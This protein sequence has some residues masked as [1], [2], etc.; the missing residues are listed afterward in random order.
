M[1]QPESLHPQRL[2]NVASKR[3]FAIFIVVVICTSESFADAYDS[4]FV[5]GFDRFHRESTE[6]A[7]SGGR[8]LVSELSCTACHASPDPELQPKRGPNLAGAGQRYQPGW[9]Q[10]YLANPQAIKPGTVMPDVMHDFTDDQRRQAADAIAA[11]LSV[12]NPDYPILESTASNPVAEEFWRKGDQE[13]GAELYHQVGCVACHEPNE[14]FPAAPYQG[15]DVQKLLSQLDPDEIEEL[16][17][18]D[19][20]RRVRSVPHG[21][22]AG[23]Y[24][25]KSLAFFLYAPERTR[26]SGRMPSFNL[27]PDEAAD[28]ASYLIGDPAKEDQDPRQ[29]Y[30]ASLVESGKRFFA[31]LRCAQCHSMDELKPSFA[32]KPLVD[33]NFAAAQT[34]AGKRSVG[35]PFYGLDPVQVRSI[36]SALESMGEQ[37]IGDAPADV[38]MLKLNCYACHQRGRRG[39][40]GPNRRRYFETVGNVDIGDEGRLPPPLDGVGRKLRSS[41]LDDALKATINVRPHMFVRM[42]KFSA[43]SMA[44]LAGEFIAADAAEESGDLFP[45]DTAK[46]A[47]SGRMLFDTGCVQCH[48]VRGEHLPG[49]LGIDLTGATKRLRAQWFHDFLLDPGSLKSRTRMPTF[50]PDGRSV[51]SEI[52][53]GDTEGQIASLW[54]YINDIENQPLPQKIEDGKAHDFELIPNEQPI[55]LRTFMKDVGTHAIAVGF[56]QKV[57]YAFDAEMARLA[58]AWRGRFIDAH[59]TWFDRFTPPAVP[60]GDDVVGFPTGVALATLASDDSPWPTNG[61]ATIRFGGFR[62]D[63]RGVPTFIYR[64][65]GFDIEDRLTPDEQGGLTRSIQVKPA[66]HEAAKPA[67][68]WFLGN[69]GKNL[70]RE[71]ARSY[72]NEDKLTVTMLQPLK[73]LGVVREINGVYEWIIPIKPEGAISIEVNYR[74]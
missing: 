33:L 47:S 67:E 20:I 63:Q 16:G 13:R 65:D 21:D 44:K 10:R 15:S 26:P 64:S 68:L 41:A 73:N 1:L 14:D 35:V 23:K 69:A 46:L 55:L 58:Q 74:W 36:E 25:L 62:I 66:D 22:L 8:L 53:G 28:I 12:R 27:T 39:G 52:L 40:V 72:T 7:A 29:H 60:L 32:A 51:N 30:R 38:S 54:A 42:P 6:G 31:E 49:V 37:S 17:L 24:S 70:K 3:L 34:C 4:P 18:T 56:G 19:A 61:Q 43:P 71:D 48:W 59:G 50:F 9:L 45:E 2:A 11:F 5:A 57:H